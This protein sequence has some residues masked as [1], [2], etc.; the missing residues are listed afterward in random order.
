MPKVSFGVVGREHA[1]ANTYPSRG[2]AY[3]GYF[4]HP[5]LAT[6]GASPYNCVFYQQQQN[7]MLAPVQVRYFDFGYVLYL[8]YCKC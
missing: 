1:S 6:S 7:M 2:D 3:R 8:G 4:T 5:V